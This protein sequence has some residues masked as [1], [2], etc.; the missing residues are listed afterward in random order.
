M[1]HECILHARTMGIKAV[2][3]DHSLFGFADLGAIHLN[4]L[5]KFTL[6]E[7]DQVVCVSHCSKEYLAL[8][9][10]LDPYEVSV[11]P[12][13]VDTSCFTSC[14]ALVPPIDQQINI[15]MLRMLSRLV[16]RKCMDLVVHVIPEICRRF[17]LVHFIIGGD[18][19]KRLPL[20]EMPRSTSCATGWRCSAP[21]SMRTSGKC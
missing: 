11:I 20:E 12:N 3:T 14:P 4:E 7:I 21:D 5:M 9:A 13:A 10:Q 15:I 17:P 19:P 8:R 2:Y 18:G 1:A 16:Y 6:S